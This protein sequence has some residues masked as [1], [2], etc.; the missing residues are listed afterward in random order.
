L[1]K[2]TNTKRNRFDIKK[3]SLRLCKA[4]FKSA[5]FYIIF[6]IFTMIIAPFEGIVNYQAPSIVF[7]IIYICFI[8]V[9]ELTQGSIYQHVFSIAN[10]L[11][12]IAYITNILELGV[13]NASIEQ[14]SMRVDLRFFLSVFMIGGFLGFTK[15]MLQLLSWLNE[16][17]EYWFAD[18]IKSL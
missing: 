17:E 13:I 7:M 4:T 14:F 11:L 16:R 8:F 6:S 2:F 9:S 12:V 10:S 3:I 18:H 15:S 5:I 1:D